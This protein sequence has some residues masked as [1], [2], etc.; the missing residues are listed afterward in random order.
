MQAVIRTAIDTRLSAVGS[1]LPGVVV[2]Y[3]SG[4]QTATVRPGVHRLV[5][6]TNEEDQDVVEPLPVIHNVP[7]CWPRG[8][9]FACIGTLQPGD[10]VLLVCMDRD[11][12][13]WRDSGDASEPEDARV[14]H[15]SSAVAI[16]GLVPN[17]SPFTPPADGAALAARLDTFFRAVAMLPDATNPIKTMAAIQAVILAARTVTGSTGAGNPGVLSLASTVLRLDG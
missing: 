14:H 16:P 6:S 2:S 10:P 5:P 15:W 7:V 4:S 9:G 11:I 12:S 13:G 1:A 3:S 8:R 17:T